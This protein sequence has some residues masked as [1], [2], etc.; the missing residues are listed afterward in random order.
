MN[1]VLQARYQ[2][3]Q[4]LLSRLGE[5][6]LGLVGSDGHDVKHEDGLTRTGNLE[7]ARTLPPSLAAAS[8]HNYKEIIS[9]RRLEVVRLAR[10]HC[11]TSSRPVLPPSGSMI[12]LPKERPLQN[13]HPLCVLSVELVKH[14][15]YISLLSSH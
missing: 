4:D 2:C 12:R 7:M 9:R 8:W 5:E 10:Y 13:W 11:A 1:T 3:R 14:Y 15:M 6:L